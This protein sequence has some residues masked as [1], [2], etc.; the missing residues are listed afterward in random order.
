MDAPGPSHVR[1]LPEPSPSIV[2]QTT[3]PSMLATEQG[4]CPS[5]RLHHRAAAML[6]NTRTTRLVDVI[7]LGLSYSCISWIRFA[8]RI[9]YLPGHDRKARAPPSLTTK[10]S[11][12][13]NLEGV[14]ALGHHKMMPYL[15]E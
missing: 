5:A 1:L 6:M 15:E 10:R 4:G 9:D 3:T 13:Q 2:S 8:C 12:C 14:G 7:H 11:V